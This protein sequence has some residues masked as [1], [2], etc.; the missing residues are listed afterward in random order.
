MKRRNFF[1]TLLGSLFVGKAVA[2][3]DSQP[4]FEFPELPTVTSTELGYLKGTTAS[5]QKQLDDYRLAFSDGWIKG[6][7]VEDENYEP[8]EEIENPKSI[9]DIAD[10]KYAESVISQLGYC[11]S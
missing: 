2:Q 9:K 10:R 8:E 6:L 7:I 11:R 4:N 5:I 3:F 1:A